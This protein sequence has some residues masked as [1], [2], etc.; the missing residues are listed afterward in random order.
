MYPWLFSETPLNTDTRT[1]WPVPLVSVLTGF[2]CIMFL[3]CHV[4][5]RTIPRK[6]RSGMST[7][8]HGGMDLDTAYEQCNKPDL[9]CKVTGKTCNKYVICNVGFGPG[10]QPPPYLFSAAKVF[11]TSNGDICWRDHI[12]RAIVCCE[13]ICQWTHFPKLLFHEAI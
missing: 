10:E 1:I 3:F 9:K 8:C 11:S 5:E 4:T 7:L 2:H 13:Y 6:R 12:Y